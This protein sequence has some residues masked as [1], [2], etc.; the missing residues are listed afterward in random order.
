M[1]EGT[2]GPVGME[3]IPDGSGTFAVDCID[4]YLCV[5]MFLTFIVLGLVWT[6]MLL[7]DSPDGSRSAVPLYLYYLMFLCLGSFFAAHGHSISGP[8]SPL[9]FPRGSLR[10][11]C[12]R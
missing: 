5:G 12:S 9:Y 11:G 1:I 2:V 7:P 10:T 4:Q 6:M 8:R 3:V